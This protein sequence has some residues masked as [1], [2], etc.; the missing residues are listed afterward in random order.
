MEVDLN[1][2]SAPKP[3]VKVRNL[4]AT[5]IVDM[6]G[7]LDILGGMT[8]IFFKML[9]TFEEISKLNE[10]LEEIAKG[11]EAN[12]TTRMKDGAHRIKGSSGYVGASRLHFATFYIH[13]CWEVDNNDY[14][15]MIKYYQSTVESAI[16]FKVYSRQFL[17]EHQ[18][19]TYQ[20]DE[21][22]VEVYI[23]RGY[24]LVPVKNKYLCIRDN[25][26]IP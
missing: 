4:D 24:S 19:T 8:N 9:S 22:D 5:Q 15:G 23:A 17:A 25:Q 21:K 14:D 6:N 7:A 2:H 16:E 3:V 26:T 20:F 18:G 10:N 12:D 1:K 13:N 11:L